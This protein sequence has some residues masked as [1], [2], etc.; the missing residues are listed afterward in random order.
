MAN[1]FGILTAIVLALSA[2]IALK[3]KGQY[4]TTI[5]DT[6]AKKDLLVK[7]QARFDTAKGVLSALPA[8]ISGVNA[9]V[10]KLTAAEGDRRAAGWKHC[11]TAD[12]KSALRGGQWR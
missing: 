4:E 8:E 12:W 2:F 10:E 1:V 6:A 9:E 5:A 11:D 3:N 7:N